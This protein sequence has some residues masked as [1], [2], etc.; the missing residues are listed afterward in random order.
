MIKRNSS[1]PPTLGHWL[2]RSRPALI[3]VALF[4]AFVNLLML[5]GP[6]FSIQVYDRVL[7]S[8][9]QVTLIALVLL[10]SFLF[11]ILFLLDTARAWLMTRVADRGPRLVAADGGGSPHR[12]G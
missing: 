4:S 8:R 1:V 5:T 11:A 9:S 10:A 2:W 6:L 7:A 3:S 12:R